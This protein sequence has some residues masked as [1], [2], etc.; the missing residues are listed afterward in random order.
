LIEARMTI[1]TPL[2]TVLRVRHPIMLA[3]MDLVADA[4]LT[5]A[6]S[7]AGGFGILGAGYGNADWLRRE[8]PPLVAARD[9]NGVRFGVGF[10][11]WSLAR[12]PELLDQVLKARPDAVWLSFGD[13]APFAAKIKA[14]GAL[15]I[16]Q[17]QTLAMA[18]HAV[19]NGA[20]IIVAQ[21][22]EAGGHGMSRGAIA[23]VPAV[24]DAVGR[25][26][27]V[28][29]A[30]G[31]ADGRGLAAA[32][33][34]GAK[35]IVLGTRFY[36]SREAAGHPD[37]KARIV[38]AS[39]DDT[40]RSIV[41]D[42]SRQNVWPAPYTGRCLLNDHARR[43]AGRE[44]ELMRQSHEETGRYLAARE[45][46]DFDVAAVIAG[47]SAG[48]VHDTPEAGVIV[49]RMID[50][51]SALLTRAPQFIASHPRAR[52]SAGRDAT[53]APKT[54]PSVRTAGRRA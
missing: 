41:F 1:E 33:M 6:V 52:T 51:A 17:V 49:Q 29:M 43:W 39:G 27:P 19:A 40:L 30:G 31:V 4:R 11:T 32:L 24:V 44:L 15:L 13:P 10:I 26:V 12:Q 8:L 7:K 9:A 48:L 14:A 42:V 37:A 36:A 3:P 18:E 54:S 38:N 23:L 5:L 45:A 28:A 53:L 46:G 21:G 34:L 25:K 35:G 2:T 16:C 22:S 20:D 47:E 50:E